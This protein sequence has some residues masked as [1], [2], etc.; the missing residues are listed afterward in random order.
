MN[1]KLV[2][3]LVLIGALAFSLGLGSYAWFTSTATSSNNLFETGTLAIGVESPL[4]AETEFKNIYPS[5]NSG[6]KTYDIKNE[7]TL[8]LKYRMT[9]QGEVGEL[10]YD[11]PTP[12]Q[13][14]INNNDFVDINQVGTVYIGEIEAGQTGELNLQFRLPEEA[15][16]DYQNEIASFTFVFEATQVDNPGWNEAGE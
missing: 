10:L 7:G 11:G 2:I 1:K 5:W 12:L 6:V 8:A 13:V 3:S 9:V 16:N 15:D 14:K 4:I